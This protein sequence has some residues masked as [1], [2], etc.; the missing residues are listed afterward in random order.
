MD[1]FSP[2]F[3]LSTYRREG[4]NLTECAFPLGGIGTGCVS[5]D[6]RGGL[7]DWEIFGRPN[8]NSVLDY[9]FPAIWWDDGEPHSRV[10]LGPR[11]KDFVGL[12]GGFW[13]YGHGRFF[14][15]M[16]GL[17]G[18]ESV[19]LAGPFPIARMR[20]HDETVPLEI[21]LAAWSPFIPQDCASSSFPCAVL[22]YRVRNRSDRKL[23]A[24]LAWS[25]LNPVGMDDPDPSGCLAAASQMSMG[26]ITGITFGNAKYPPG[27]LRHGE[28]V[29]ATN[30]PETSVLAAWPKED[31]WDSVR[32]VWSAFRSTG[33]FDGVSG[34]NT[35]E[36]MPGSLACLLTLGPGEE[37][38]V[39]FVIGWRFP[40]FKKIWTQEGPLLTPHYACRWSSASEA[41]E[42]FF[43][44]QE[45]LTARTLAFEDA[46]LNSSLDPV[47][48]ESVA[49]PL[50]T[51]RTPTLIH[52]DDGAYWG[53]EGCSQAEGC[54]EGTCSHVW[55]YSL[56]H[57]YLFPEIQRSFLDSAF[58]HS[59]RCGPEG[60][61]GAM[62][63]RVPLPMIQ[64]VPLWHAA[65]DG[66]LGQ[67]IQV[68]REW[69][70][71]GDKAWL[72]GLWPSLKRSL[73][74]S[75]SQ[76][77]RDKDGLVEGDM[78]NT[79]DINFQGPNPLTQFFYLGA[80]RAMEKLA[81]VMEDPICAECREIA[82]RGKL[83]TE[84]RLWNGEWF[85][86]EGD[87]SRH[88]D[89]RYQHGAGCLADQLLGQNL[90]SV[91]GLGPLVDPELIRG[92]LA[93]IFRWNWKDKLGL[94][95]NLQRAYAMP[96]EPGLLLCTWPEDAPPFFPFPYSDEV[97]TGF[98]HQVASHLMREGM[99]DEAMAILSGVRRRHDGTRRSPWNEFECGSH[100]ARALASYGL[101]LSVTGQ[102]F[103]APDQRLEFSQEP[104]RA[105]FSLPGAWGRAE[106]TPEGELLLEVIEG[107]LPPS[108]H[109]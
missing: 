25:L 9:T 89:T 11:Q 56:S 23:S 65:S 94:H 102:S 92:A 28:V 73:A 66:Q 55:N 27:S 103:S 70:L 40:H 29:L 67:I 100:Y 79:Y 10:L 82:D 33:R 22:S 72:E 48:L 64:E 2:S 58:A 3:D 104:F 36:R 17:P 21:Q 96:D 77:D 5:L 62:R 98:E 108:V 90:A 59:F 83:L 31:W 75:W 68:W 71:T 57:A 85:I 8:K 13:D 46:L 24:S 30:W 1:L 12:S 60:E 7:R 14:H 53:W 69:L 76:W 61:K 84:Q 51:L 88:E 80:L 78:H 47:V 93:S 91:A 52:L 97:W 34:P 50:S 41:V 19:D 39:T 35:S 6:G 95:E 32:S 109:P 81:E 37:A 16:D 87:F 49:A 105:F 20:F 26:G 4:R 18:F 99:R 106:R 63:F 54:C 101:L 15:Q 44:S 43:S 74:Y 45:E 86:Q 107:S 38:D 42:E